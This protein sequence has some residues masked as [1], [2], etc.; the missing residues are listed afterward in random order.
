METAFDIKL[1]DKKKEE[2]MVLDTDKFQERLTGIFR[3]EGVTELNGGKKYKT[4]PESKFEGNTPTKAL[5]SSS[6]ILQDT[7]QP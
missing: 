3:D 6:S 4:I 2:I 1:I 7:G 5:S